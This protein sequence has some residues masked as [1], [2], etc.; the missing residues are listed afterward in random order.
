VAQR[1]FIFTWLPPTKIFPPSSFAICKQFITLSKCILLTSAPC[2]VFSS[3]GSP[4]VNWFVLSTNSSLNFSYT[5]FSINIL[6]PHKQ[7]CPWLLNDD[8]IVIFIIFSQLQSAKMIFGFFPPNSNDNFLNIGAATDAILAPAFVLPVKEIA[9]IS[10]CLMIASPVVFPL[11]C[12]I[13]NTPL[14]N[15]AS[16]QMRLNKKAVTGVISDGFAI[17]QFPAANAGAIFH[18]N[19][20]NGRFH[21]EMHATIPSG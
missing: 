21:G 7:I 10:G 3:N 14:G 18:V 15:P 4:I 8:C 9:F 12:T 17:T 11:P 19:K 13:F 2:L 5:L 20:Y 1:P 16:L 6:L